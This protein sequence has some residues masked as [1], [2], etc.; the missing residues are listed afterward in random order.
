MASLGWDE[1]CNI[2]H[3]LQRLFILLDYEFPGNWHT[4]ILCNP[5][6]IP[7]IAKLVVF[8]IHQGEFGCQPMTMLPPPGPVL[9][10]GVEQKPCQL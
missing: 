8:C 3:D 2:D 7:W 1:W 5:K 9:D 6:Y 10:A 4:K